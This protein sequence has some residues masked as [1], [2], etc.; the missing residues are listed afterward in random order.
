MFQCKHDLKFKLNTGTIKDVSTFY[1]P[2]TGEPMTVVNREFNVY[3]CD[4]CHCVVWDKE[5]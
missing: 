3:L 2:N 5:K 1:N 4:D